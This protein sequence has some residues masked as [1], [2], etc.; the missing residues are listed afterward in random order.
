M[1]SRNKEQNCQVSILKIK[2]PASAPGRPLWKR[3]QP[4]ARPARGALSGGLWAA[5]AFRT[6]L[7]VTALV[8]SFYFA[9]LCQCLFPLRKLG[10]YLPMVMFWLSPNPSSELSA[11]A[12]PTEE[13][14]L[15]FFH[16]LTHV[17]LKSD[18]RFSIV[19]NNGFLFVCF[20]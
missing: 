16:H 10:L 18:E 12:H 13:W 15:E 9:E 19:S 4:G 20:D 1:C 7:K 5:S 11:Y 8:H 14:E 2:S 3:R 17:L 6:G